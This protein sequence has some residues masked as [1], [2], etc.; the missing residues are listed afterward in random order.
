MSRRHLT[1]RERAWAEDAAREICRRHRISTADPEFLAIG[2]QA[3]YQLYATRPTVSDARFWPCVYQ[4]MER[5]L[6]REKRERGKIKYALLSLN[7]PLAP[8]R[9]ATYLDVL[10]ARQGDFSNGVVLRDYLTRLPRDQSD[11]AFRLM[12]QDTPE[13]AHAALGWDTTRL[14]TAMAQLR[15]AMEVYLAI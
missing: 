5:D 6:L 8:D 15:Q 7:E 13:E 2:M 12:A 3:F 11:L 1:S 14:Q 10:R 9:S 4:A